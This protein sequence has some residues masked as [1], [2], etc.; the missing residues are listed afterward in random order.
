MERLKE[1]F[2]SFFISPEFGTSTLLVAIFAIYEN[3]FSWLGEIIVANELVEKSYYIPLGF[4]LYSFYRLKEMLLPN[5]RSRK[6]LVKWQ[7][8]PTYKDTSFVGVF[9]LVFSVII[10]STISFVETDLG[11]STICLFLTVAY[12]ISLSSFITMYFA[13]VKIE[14]ILE[15]YT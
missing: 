13:S 15:K 9:Y 8:F 6:I 4:L 10:T 12:S 14:E 11:K 3:P 7:D 1:I 2:F 5:H